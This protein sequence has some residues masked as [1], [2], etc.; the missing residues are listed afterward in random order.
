MLS[1]C[2]L[3]QL[4]PMDGATLHVVKT[5]TRDGY[6][7]VFCNMSRQKHLGANTYLKANLLPF[8][9]FDVIM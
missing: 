1:K 2:A 3:R 9:L 7:E 4:G 8:S 5:S 6:K